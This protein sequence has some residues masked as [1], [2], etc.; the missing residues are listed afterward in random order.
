MSLIAG[1]AAVKI[2]P[3]EVGTQ[4][5][6]VVNKTRAAVK[7]VMESETTKKVLDTGAKGV[8]EA[9]SKVVSMTKARNLLSV[10]NKN[11]EEKTHGP[12]LDDL[13]KI[14]EDLQAQAFDTA[15]DARHNAAQNLQA[16]LDQIQSTATGT[17]DVGFSNTVT[18]FN[19]RFGNTT[20]TNYLVKVAINEA[21]CAIMAALCEAPDCCRAGSVCKDEFVPDIRVDLCTTTPPAPTE[22]LI[23]ASTEASTEAPTTEAPTTEAPTDEAPTEAPIEEAPIEEAPTEEAP[24]EEAPIEEA[25]T[26]EVPAPPVQEE[27]ET[28]N[29]EQKQQAH[30]NIQALLTKLDLKPVMEPGF[31]A[32]SESLN[33]L[34][35]N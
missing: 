2:T 25:L 28:M 16:L 11:D 18:G 35:T 21:R 29:K 33:R 17:M 13:N 27:E 26:E 23:E 20:H 30:L 1:A 7:T 4:V 10:D 12:L 19:S 14:I 6:S 3:D 32:L 22:A 8:R 9:Y 15:T 5:L 31:D 34:M 24:S